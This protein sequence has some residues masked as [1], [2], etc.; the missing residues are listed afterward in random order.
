[1]DFYSL[2]KDVRAQVS[3]P[4]RDR[5]KNNDSN[6]GSFLE[7]PEMGFLSL[8]LELGPAL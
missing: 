7:T 5:L 2:S 4:L 3:C 6:I 1:M 8:P